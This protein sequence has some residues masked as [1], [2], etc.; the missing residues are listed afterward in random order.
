MIAAFSHTLLLALL[1]ADATV[2]AQDASQCEPQDSQQQQSVQSAGPNAAKPQTN[3]DENKDLDLIPDN[4]QQ[5]QSSA[6]APPVPS[7]ANQRIYIENA[8]IFSGLR[9]GLLVAAPLP[10]ASTWEERLFLDIRKEWRL[11]DRLS[12]TLSDRLNLRGEENLLFP[13][14]EN[15]INDF[16]EGYLS[17][18][19]FDRTYLDAGR[20]NLK[21]G[22]ALGFNPT[23]FFKTRAVVEPLS[24]DPSVLR[25]DRLGTLM[26]RAQHIWEGGAIMAAFAPGFYHPTAIY[27]D[28][29]L[30]SFNPSFDRT[31]AHDRLL[32]KA[33]INFKTNFSPEL[34]IYREG[35]QTKIG[36]NVTRSLGQS[37]VAYAEWAGGTQVNLIDRALRYGRDTG[38]LPL[39]APSPLSDDPRSRFQND[40][41]LGASYATRNKIT[42]NLEYHLHEAGFTRQDWNHWSAA[43]QGTTDSS[44][45]AR[46]LWYIRSYALDQQEPLSRHSAFL[47]ADW[48]DAFI[49][50]LEITGFTNADLYDGSSLVQVEADY[51]VSNAW[52]VGAQGSAYLGSRRSDFGSLP[53]RE[54]FLLKVARYF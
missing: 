48:V 18:E 5:Q 36:A 8:L 7:S 13:N 2:A 6:P 1:C 31:N 46:A 49:P 45:A 32:L 24:A 43:G 15:V 51:Y 34:L 29:N 41:S 22:A 19:P 12:L 14:H 20:I 23:D 10:T 17:W 9:G 54:G 35:N 33:S 28:A 53:Q 40:L 38:T 4:A 47:R 27:T 42:F 37:I 3:K 52:T 30:P 16:R 26:V 39:S 50:H 25:E 21:N 11:Y 44:P